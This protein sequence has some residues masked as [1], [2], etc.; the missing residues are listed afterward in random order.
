MKHLK[1][2]IL[3]QESINERNIALL[4]ENFPGA[5]EENIDGSFTVN[6][7]KLQMLID[8]K[9]ATIEENGYELNW[10]GK[11][12]AYHTAFSKNTKILKPL[13]ADSKDFD[14]TENILI[15]GDNLD[16]LKI[17]KNNYFEAIKMIYIDPPYNTKSENFV[18]RDNF[19]KSLEETME[20]LGYDAENIDYIKNIQGARTHSGWL[21]F[22]YPRLLLA[23]DLL[24][25]EGVVFISIDDNEQANLKVLADEVF[26]TGNFIANL[27]VIMNLKGNQDSFG[28]ADTHEYTLV[29]A[30]DKN[31]CS[32][33][34]FDIDEDELD[35]W[36]EDDWGLYKKA[37]TLRRTG[38]DASRE[39][40]QKGWFPIFI[41]ESDEIYV[42]ND[43]QPKN[44]NDIILW[45]INE[46]GEELSWTW[47]KK[48]ITDEPHNLIL[49][50]GRQ[51]K[52]IYK[53]QR[54]KL[55]DLPTKKPKSV[56]YKPEYST[57]TATTQLKNLLGK[58]VFDG[59]KPVPFISDLIMLATQEND[60][61]LDFFAGSGT[62][63]HS[64][65]KFNAEYEQNRKFILIQLPEII[66]LKK[67]KDAYEYVEKTLKKTTSTIFEITAERLRRSGEEVKSMYKYLDN[68]QNLDIGFRV[69]EIV[70]DEKQAI[71]KK[72]LEEASQADLTLLTMPQMED[73]DT[74]LYNLLVAEALPLSTKINCLKENAFY[75]ADNVAFIVGDIKLEEVSKLLAEHKKVEYITIYSPL[76][77]DN[78]FSLEVGN[79]LTRLGFSND[80]LRFRG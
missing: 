8:P 72:S 48:K 52:N 26:G 29:Y 1:Q 19:T 25:D 47:S 58:K 51:G 36:T 61:I 30:K 14:T 69:F 15:K 38:Q 37:D 53:K 65:M 28:F 7:N 56:F 12:E 6:A 3:T 63:G 16:A 44:Q 21:S 46:D 66:S 64:V 55:G 22:M 27:S 20:E 35:D 67:N 5:I 43:D 39:K 9:N 11:K 4:R 17:L 10:V 49:T 75:I 24:K 57:S 79:E 60:I 31:K 42:S 68:I 18:Y 32:L 41:T 76:V 70:K 80:K 62:T 13:K 71:Y 50:D 23:R 59:P 2:D 54:P 33:G 34:V 74:V 73:I 40:R 45:P 78:K 77:N